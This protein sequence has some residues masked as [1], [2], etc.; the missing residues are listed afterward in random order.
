ML[1]TKA[2]LRVAANTEIVRTTDHSIGVSLHGT[3]VVAFNAD[4]SVALNSGGYRTA[5]TKARINSALRRSLWRV[6]Q[7]GG[8]WFL[9]ADENPRRGHLFADGMTLTLGGEVTL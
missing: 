5:T 4:G 1:G 9:S 7:V 6:A 8:K 2:R 3:V